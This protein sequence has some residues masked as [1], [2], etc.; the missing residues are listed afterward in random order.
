MGS[1]DYNYINFRHFRHFV[2]LGIS[3]EELGIDDFEPSLTLE[4][5]QATVG[6]LIKAR[7]GIYHPALGKSPGMRSM[8]PK[9]HSH[10]PGTFWYYN[11]WDFNA[12]MKLAIN[13]PLKHRK[14]IGSKM[15]T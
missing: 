15:T 10:P 9:R 5:K 8:R 13:L 1:N 4:E 12:K 14:A 7:S 11:N 3:L 6:D 2:I